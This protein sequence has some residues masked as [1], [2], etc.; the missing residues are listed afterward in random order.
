MVAA[1]LAVGV[2]VL[3]SN[4]SCG[5]T[6][7]HFILLFNVQTTKEKFIY[8]YLWENGKMMMMKNT[9]RVEIKNLS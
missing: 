6:L 9:R 8:M 4:R 1:I 5:A 3:N 7:C 2:I